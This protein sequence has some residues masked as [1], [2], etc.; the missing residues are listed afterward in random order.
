MYA[1]HKC[2]AVQRST[3]I[4]RAH[5]WTAIH[6]LPPHTSA[7]ASNRDRLLTLWAKTFQGPSTTGL[8]TALLNGFL[9]VLFF[10]EMEVR[11]QTK[12]TSPS[13]RIKTGCLGIPENSS[14]FQISFFHHR[15][16]KISTEIVC[17]HRS[18]CWCC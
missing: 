2:T 12:V 11:E 18:E 3:E 8:V 4:P 16:I 15:N 7:A 10:K 9:S 5:C 1:I 6:V 13:T 17:T 14:C